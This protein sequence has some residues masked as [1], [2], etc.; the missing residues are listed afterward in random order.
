MHRMASCTR[1]ADSSTRM[2]Q[3]RTRE[4][5]AEMSP[6]PC[7]EPFLSASSFSPHHAI[8]SQMRSRMTGEFSPIPPPKIT[9]SRTPQHGQVSADVLF[10][11]VAEHP[12]RQSGTRIVCFALEQ[13]A[14]TRDVPDTPSKPERRLS[15]SS[16][17]AT[18]T[19]SFRAIQPASDGST[20]PLRVPITSPS[21]GVK[22]ID[23]SMLLPP[24]TAAAE[25]RCRA[26]T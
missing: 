5:A 23:V 16:T 3:T 26:G 9:A 6:A 2:T 12:H 25:H 14:H 17:R 4:L 1:I 21:S 19:S 11:P 22:P 20:S 13:I 8:P 15:Q 10:H 24:R 18:S 7:S